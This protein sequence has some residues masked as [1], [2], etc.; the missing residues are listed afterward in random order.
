M[1]A[2]AEKQ[3]LHWRALREL[4]EGCYAPVTRVNLFNIAR[5]LFKTRRQIWVKAVITTAVLPVI[6][7]NGAS[8]WENNTE[9]ETRLTWELPAGERSTTCNRGNIVEMKQTQQESKS[10]YGKVGRWL[11]VISI[12]ESA[13]KGDGEQKEGFKSLKMIM[14]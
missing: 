5:A 11:V 9:A 12:K 3:A 13:L 2:L 7:I 10:C 8:Q 6:L 4:L 14:Y 1:K